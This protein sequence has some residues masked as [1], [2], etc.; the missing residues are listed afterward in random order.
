MDRIYLAIGKERCLNFPDMNQTQLSVELL[1]LFLVNLVED[2]NHK[3]VAEKLPVS[4]AAR[5]RA[6]SREHGDG[7]AEGSA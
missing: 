7:S 3:L 1:D 2:S 6:Q 4:S 5:R